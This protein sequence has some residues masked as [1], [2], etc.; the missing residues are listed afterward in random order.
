MLSDLTQIVNSDPSPL[1]IGFCLKAVHQWQPWKS[2]KLSNSLE[3]MACVWIFVVSIDMDIV[4]YQHPRLGQHPP[5]HGLSEP[6][7][8]AILQ[9]LSGAKP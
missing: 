4:C 8:V 6:L 3:C 2:R 1:E 9:D 7:P 5:G